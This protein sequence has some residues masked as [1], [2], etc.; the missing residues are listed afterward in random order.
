MIQKLVIIFFSINLALY[1][2]LSEVDL[3]AAIKNNDADAVEK[4]LRSGAN[5]NH[6]IAKGDNKGTSVLM[7]AVYS[8]NLKIIRMLIEA[9]ANP[10][11]TIKNGKY[12]G[13]SV[14][15]IALST[16]Q[17]EIIQMI[18]KAGANVN[19]ILSDA[20]LDGLSMLMLAIKSKQYEATKILLEKGAQVN[21]LAPTTSKVRSIQNKTALD[22]AYEIKDNKIIQLVENAG[23]RRS[24]DLDKVEDSSWLEQL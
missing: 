12:S 22:L 14:L 9:G 20:K 5:S 24:S 10:D 4:A 16:E 3:I 7:L 19:H 11:Y 1:A 8:K 2:R 15:L 6:V 18:T 17:P 21:Y 13:F 23:G